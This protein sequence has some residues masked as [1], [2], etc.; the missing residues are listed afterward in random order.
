MSDDKPPEA[1]VNIESKLEQ[2]AYADEDL[3]YVDPDKRI[4][5]GRVQWGKN[6]NPK[7][8]L[9]DGSVEP[10]EEKKERSPK[11]AKGDKP[12]R[13]SRVLRKRYYPWGTYR[14]MKRV[15]KIDGKPPKVEP[16][17]T[18]DQV[19]EKALEQPFW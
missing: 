2:L 14:S 5:V 3:V 9:M 11:D 19:M 15:Y 1:T 10:L 6:G 7:P 17:D 12:D 13:K 8:M 18:L 16:I 4:V